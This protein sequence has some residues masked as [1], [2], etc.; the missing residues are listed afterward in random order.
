MVERENDRNWRHQNSADKRLD[1]VGED[2]G[3][4]ARLVRRMRRQAGGGAHEPKGNL[5]NVALEGKVDEPVKEALHVSPS[6]V[7]QR[8]R[9]AHGFAR[10]GDEM[11]RWK[12][13]W[14]SVQVW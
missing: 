14:C 9:L 4:A 5:E 1:E 11:E 3:D 6:I 12:A 10:H 13:M 8:R 7:E 2:V